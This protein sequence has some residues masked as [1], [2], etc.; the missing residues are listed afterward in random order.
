MLHNLPKA[1]DHLRAHRFAFTCALLWAIASHSKSAACFMVW[2]C[3]WPLVKTLISRRSRNSHTKPPERTPLWQSPWHARTE[4][5]EN[6]RTLKVYVLGVGNQVEEC[7]K[8]SFDLNACTSFEFLSERQVIT[9]AFFP[10]M[11]S[12]SHCVRCDCMCSG[13]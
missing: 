5:F 4:K 7:H 9:Q 1:T 6:M 2:H 10:F 11:S 3:F 12:F 13:N 8:Y